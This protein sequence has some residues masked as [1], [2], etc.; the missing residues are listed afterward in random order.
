[1]SLFSIIG[2]FWRDVK[3]LG[4]PPFFSAYPCP[5]KTP[6]NLAPKKNLSSELCVD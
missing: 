1:M 5:I 2:L 6:Q 3:S 4:S